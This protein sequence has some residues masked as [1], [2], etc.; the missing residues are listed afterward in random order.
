[1][2]GPPIVY[3]GY[4]QSH[5]EGGPSGDQGIDE[6]R[7]HPAGS[8]RPWVGLGIGTVITEEALGVHREGVREL[9]AVSKQDHHA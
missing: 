7:R 4:P 5:R 2:G 1:M 6:C 3:Q 9:Q 8:L